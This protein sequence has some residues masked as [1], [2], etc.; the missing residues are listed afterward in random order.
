MLF[1]LVAALHKFLLNIKNLYGRFGENQDGYKEYFLKLDGYFFSKKENGYIAVIRVRNKRT[2]D[3]ITIKDIIQD[4]L[5]LRELHPYDNC[6]LGILANEERNG[7][8]NIQYT[9]VKNMC[10]LRDHQCIIK[11]E[12]ALRIIK[13]YANNE[14]IEITILEAKYLGKQLE[15]PTIALSENQALLYALDQFEAISV[16]FNASEYIVKQRKVT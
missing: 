12:P 5:Y 11:S 16:G 10:R 7:N 14:G 13:T 6:I 4:K 8:I 9:G 3:L 15:I 2:T 1:R